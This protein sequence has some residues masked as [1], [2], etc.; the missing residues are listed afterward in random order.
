MAKEGM[1]IVISGPAGCGKDTIVAELLADSDKFDGGLSYSV[2]ATT[3]PIRKGEQDG[4]HYHFKTRE[5]FERCIKDGEFLEY[6]E[7]CG[8]YY[9]TLKKAVA[10]VLRQGRNII[11]KIEVEGAANV[12]RMFTELYPD[13]EILSIFIMPPSEQ[14]LRRRLV[15]RSTEDAATIETR[16]KKAEEEMRLAVDYDCQ[17]VNGDLQTA[18]NEIIEIIHKKK[19]R[20]ENL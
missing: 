17:V 19:S 20:A 4:V 11:L 15:N 18:V 14:E 16:I 6:T 8:N 10:D 2:S 7:Y 9:G 13:S 12:R 1:L 3:R 5:E